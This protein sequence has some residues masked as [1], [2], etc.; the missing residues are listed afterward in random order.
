MDVPQN[1]LKQLSSLVGER[2]AAPPPSI[3]LSVERLVA[4]CNAPHEKTG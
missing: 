1:L 4:R 2:I 3:T